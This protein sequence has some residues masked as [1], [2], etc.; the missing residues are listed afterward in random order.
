MQKSLKNIGFVSTRLAGSDGVSLETAKWAA[1]MERNGC[2]CFYFAG[3]L[4]RPDSVSCLS[5]ES[6]FNHDE[7]IRI[8][9][10]LFETQGRNRDVS[11]TVDRIKKKIKSSLYEFSRRFDIDLLI[12]ENAITIPMNIPLGLAVTEFIAETGMS[13]LAHHHDFFWERERFL[14]NRAGDYLAAAFPPVLPG[15]IHVTI[16]S[17]GSRELSFRKGVSSTV[18]PNVYDF[19]NH[20]GKTDGTVVKGIRSAAG[21]NDSVPM[22]LQPTRI[23]SRK[24]I[25]RSIELVSRL[26]IDRKALVISHASGDEGNEYRDMLEDYSSFLGVKLVYLDSLLSGGSK[27]VTLGDIYQASDFVLY[28]SGYEGFGNAF[29]ETVYYGKPI[30]VNRYPVFIADIEPLGFDVV[31][32]DGIVTG[33]SV[34]EVE[35]LLSDQSRIQRAVSR[36]YTVA[37]EYFSLEVL[38]KKLMGLVSSL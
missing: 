19:R 30:L 8:N 36:N 3:E 1:V 15:L 21:L 35:D 27:P 33:R 12:P 38:E 29:L 28:P 20:P 24:W 10:S 23:V 34:K 11:V 16:N 18:I 25:E 6:H 9:D 22:F 14:V 5:E 26:N 2:H 4:D 32:I 37:R 13:A 31:S 7:S 17:I